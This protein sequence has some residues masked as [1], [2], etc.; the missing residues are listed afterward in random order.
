MKRLPHPNI[1]A[2][3]DSFFV[4]GQDK[5]CIVMTYCDGGDLQ[6][7]L[8]QQ[9]GKPLAEDQILH[10]FVQMALGV[11]FMH[12]NKVL[13]RDL[14]TQNVFLLSS[15]RLVLG[16][17]GIS[18]TLDGT[19]A[20]AKTQIGTP[21]YMSPELFKNKPYNHKSDVWSLGC[22]LYE[23]CTLRHPFEA[24]S[25]QQLAAKI[26]HGRYS[27]ISTKFSRGLRSLVDSLLSLSPADRP[28]IDD[29]LKSPFLRKPLAEFVRD[30]SRRASSA[31]V[32]DGT[33]ALGK[34]FEKLATG[35]GE[36]M[37]GPHSASLFHQLRGLGLG[38]LVTR[39]LKPVEEAPPAPVERAP[40][41]AAV[42]AETKP[43]APERSSSGRSGSARRALREQQAALRREKEVQLAVERALHAYEEEKRQRA[44][45]RKRQLDAHRKRLA[46]AAHSKARPPARATRA[47]PVKAPVADE[48]PVRR[49]A[50]KPV[51]ARPAEVPPPVDDPRSKLA[52][53][54]AAQD[55]EMAQW[56]AATGQRARQQAVEAKAASHA[57]HV[58]VSPTR[59]R[60]VSTDKERVLARRQLEREARERAELERLDAARQRIADERR[61][62][63]SAQRGMYLGQGAASS[64][65]QKL[66]L[67]GQRYEMSRVRSDGDY[68]IEG[69]E[70]RHRSYSVPPERPVAAE[71]EEEDDE[72]VVEEL[73]VE[74]DLEAAEAEDEEELNRAAVELRAAFEASVMRCDTLQRS[75]E[76]LR[77]EAASPVHLPGVSPGAKELLLDDSLARGE[78]GDEEE[79]DDD[80][81]PMWGDDWTAEWGD[82]HDDGAHGLSSPEGLDGGGGYLGKRAVAVRMELSKEVGADLLEAM[83]RVERAR[84]E[85]PGADADPRI[86]KDIRDISSKLGPDRSDVLQRVR[87]LVHV[88]SVLAI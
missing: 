22:I 66:S 43:A 45:W 61:A 53:M 26:V 30:T 49:R 64:V 17:L 31:E 68:P 21:Y 10:W 54:Q 86:A 35:D 44:Q 34:A 79:E 56:V 14:K 38:G 33:I 37:L 15:G 62:A 87:E 16:D 72:D 32:G 51:V 23:L 3:K 73:G 71:A 78:G 77:L 69:E 19:M 1:V 46:V 55:K 80:G 52:E 58:V 81:A 42:V 67:P 7:R 39:V 13:H 83:L 59:E 41:A 36:L 4:H 8:E 2:F 9:K 27:P 63:V 70:G 11:G 84:M 75:I 74:T 57:R 20:M 24:Q 85:D 18:K 76:R 88:E 6:T 25:I 5:L 40:A 48:A 50:A 12:A 65:G 82:A 28:T 60:S 29:V 47:E